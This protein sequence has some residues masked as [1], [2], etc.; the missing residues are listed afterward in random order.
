MKKLA[1]VLCFISYENRPTGEFCSYASVSDGTF[2]AHGASTSSMFRTETETFPIRMVTFVATRQCNLHFVT[3]N[4]QL[5]VWLSEYFYSYFIY[6][7]KVL[8]GT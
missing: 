5:V 6:L 8:P 4:T 7:A 2:S 3:T 1:Q